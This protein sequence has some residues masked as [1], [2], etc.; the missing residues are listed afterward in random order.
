MFGKF[1]TSLSS[2]SLL[3]N[4][5]QNSSCFLRQLYK[6]LNVFHVSSSSMHPVHGTR[7]CTTT[8]TLL[9]V[10]H[11]LNFPNLFLILVHVLRLIPPS[12]WLK[13]SS[14][15]YIV[16]SRALRN[17]KLKGM[18]ANAFSNLIMSKSFLC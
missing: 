11:P 5:C 16:P 1:Q 9:Q 17:L 13:K 12:E 10:D 15:N 14:I 18:G 2:C 4:F 8:F 6:C 3:G 7:H